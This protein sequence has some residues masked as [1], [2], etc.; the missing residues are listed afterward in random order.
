MQQKIYFHLYVVSNPTPNLPPPK[1]HYHGHT[2]TSMA[3]HNEESHLDGQG[4]SHY[5]TTDFQ[6]LF[7]A[8]IY[9]RIFCLKV[10]LGWSLQCNQQP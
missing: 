8:I 6:T 7:L 4:L 9:F 10:K 1:V 3:S 2:T 5:V